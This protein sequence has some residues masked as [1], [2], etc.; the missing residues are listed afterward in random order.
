[1]EQAV[2]GQHAS[3]LVLLKGL[4]GEKGLSQGVNGGPGG[5]FGQEPDAVSDRLVD[6][7]DVTAGDI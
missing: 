3:D 1:M 2:L 6:V 7:G 5:G 4:S